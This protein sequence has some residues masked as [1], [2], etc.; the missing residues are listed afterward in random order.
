MRKF[1]IWGPM[2]LIIAAGLVGLAVAPAVAGTKCEHVNPA[3]G[4]C[5]VYVSVPTTHPSPVYNDTGSGAACYWDPAKQHLPGPPA[6]PVPC[7]SPQYG[8]WSNFYNCYVQLARPQPPAGDPM[9]QG[10]QPSNGAIYSC[11]QPET[12]MTATFWSATTP[13]GSGAGPSP[14]AV[15]QIA[16]AKMKLSA[17]DIG[18]APKPGPNSVGLVGMPVWMWAN[19]PNAH[20]FG[21]I[22]ESASAGGITITATGHVARVIWTMGDGATVACTSPGTPYEPSFGGRASPDCGHVYQ[23]SSSDQPG[24][25]YTVTAT[26][27]WVVSWAGAGQSGTVQLNGLSHSTQIRIGEAQVLV[28]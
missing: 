25:A 20:T 11:Y 19:A 12:D 21:P 22:T 10:H 27:Y 13:P 8:Y 15:A 7:T 14:R 6:G 23:R 4:V 3:T 17:I 9:W 24:Q 18:I 16:I 28:N 1:L 5:V 2:T 26:S